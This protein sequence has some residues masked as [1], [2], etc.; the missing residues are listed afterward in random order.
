MSLAKTILARDAACLV[1]GE[2]IRADSGKTLD[3]LNPATSEVLG[4]VPDCGRDETARAIDAAAQAWPAWRAMTALERSAILLRLHDL[5]LAEREEL[6]RLMT[7]EQGKPLAEARGEIGFGASFLRWFA[8]E[9]RRAYGSI[10]PAPWRDKRILVTREPVGVVGI[11]TPW[12]FPTAMICRKAGPALAVGCPVVV[13]PASQTPFSALALAELARQAGVPDGVFN[14]LTGSSREIGAE[15]TGNPV[16]R[17][18]SFTGSTKVGKELLKQCAATVKKV[19][20]ELGGNA[21]FLVFDD[22]DLDLAVAGAVGSKYRNTGQTCVCTNRFLIQDGVYEAFL[23]KFASAVGQLKVGD[24]LEEGVNQGPLIDDKAVLHMEAQIADAQA[25]GGRVVL[26]GRRH[27]LGGNFFEPTIIADAVPEMVMSTEETFGPVA[28]VYRFH[29]E[30]E[31]VAL[32]NATEFGLAGYVYTRDLG[33][34]WRVSEALEYGLVGVN[35]S[36]MST[37]E[38]PFGGVKESGFGREGSQYGLDDYTTL[39]YVCMAGLGEQK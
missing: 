35:E 33:R 21:P 38:A 28:P 32:A 30:Q 12:N 31:V 39:K 16:V 8:E 26:G 23:Q 5:M 36:L 9:G 18:L 37:C 22:A 7:L 27:A 10:I 13:K 24:G 34:A 1:G 29:T 14:V 25:K 19:S 6:A 4:T 20:L 17:K 2:W 15:L 11:I 3:V